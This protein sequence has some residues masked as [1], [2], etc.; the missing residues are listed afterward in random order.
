MSVPLPPVP[1]GP[2][3]PPRPLLLALFLGFLWIR[4]AAAEDEAPP[5]YQDLCRYKWEAVDLENRVRYSLRLCSSSPPAGCG[6]GAAACARG[7]DGGEE[8]SV[9]ELDLLTFS[10]S[11]LNFNST[12]KCSEGSN[13]VQT[14]ISFQCGKTLG[15]PELVAVSQCVHYFEWKSYTACRKDSFKPHTEVP[16][17]V[18][19]SDGKKHD[20]SPLIR[21]QDGYL[22]D[23][24]DDSVDFYINI[25]RSL[26]TPGTPCP[27]GSAACLVS[28]QGV[29]G[30]GSPKSPL[31]LLSGDSLR[32]QYEASPDAPRPE[33]C[34]DHQPAVSVTLLCPSSRSPGSAPK[35]TAES[36]CRFEVLWVTEFACHRDYLE[37]RTCRLSSAEHGTSIDLSP[38]VLSSSEPPYAAH[39]DGYVFYLNVCG[40]VPSSECGDDPYVSSC[41]VKKN[42]DLKKVAGRF[43]NQTLRFSD[44]DLTLIYPDGGRCS[45]GFHRMT[46][47]NF[48]CNKTAGNGGRGTPVF[49]GETDCSYLFS[50]ETAFSC[51]TEPE[52]L[53][54]RAGTGTRRYD[55]SP[56]TRFPG[57]DPAENWE[58][59]DS[60]RT[61]GS[62]FFLNV[63]HQVLLAGGA[64]G[65]PA[66]AA[67]CAL[68]EKNVSLSLGSFL[69][70]PQL[71]GT[72]TGT[73]LRL[74]YSEGSPCPDRKNRI[75]SII[76]LRCRPGDVDSAP[77]LRRVSSDGCLYE[78]DWF[79]SAACVLSR[80]Q[81]DNCRVEDAATGL[82]FDLSPLSRSPDRPYNVT[83]GQY[84]F[85]INVC[86]AVSSCPPGA[87]A[88]QVSSSD[89]WSLGEANSRLS[90]YDGLIQLSYANGS[91]YND[92]RHTLR[93]ALLA[94]LCDPEAGAGQPQFQEEDDYTYNFR[95]YTAYACPQ[96]PHECLVTDPKTRD[97][98]DLSSL[99]RPAS[100]RNWETVDL[101]DVSNLKKFY[102][103]V[104]RPLSP[105]PG[106]DATASA[107]Q[108]KYVTDQGAPREAVSIRNLGVS[109]RGPIIESRDRVLL[110]F[111]DGSECSA[112]GLTLAYRTHLH[113]V[114]S[115]GGQSS[116]PQFLMFQN[117]T[118]TFLWETQAA[119][120]ISTSKNSNCSVVD[121]NTGFQFHLDR[122]ASASGY[123]AS[124]NNKDFVV[125]ICADAAPCGTGAAGCELE[126]GVPS[127]PVGVERTLQYSTDGVLQLTYKGLL[128]NHTAT[129]DTFTVDFVC[130]PR[131][132]PGSLRL[133]RE[134]MSTLSTL[135]V[136]NVLFE[137]STALVC[138]PAPV[139][140]RI[141]DSQGNEYDLS[142]LTRSADD[143]PWIPLDP[144]ATAPR[145]FYINVCEP[146]PSLQDCP[147]G[148][149]GACRTQDGRGSNLGYVQS[150]PQV[151]EDGTV[152]IQYL[153][154]DACGT[155]SRFSTR[156]VFQCDDKPS[157]PMLD[158]QDGCEFVFVWRTPQACP[159]RKAQG[160]DCRVRDPRTGV[161]LD[162]SPLKGRDFSVSPP[163]L[164]YSYRL[165]VCGALRG[166]ACTHTHTDRVASCQLDGE[167]HRVAGL[168]SEVLDFV[169]DQII[170][171]YSGGETCHQVYQRTTQIHFQC[172]RDQ[173][174]GEPEFIRETADC[175]YLFTWRTALAC[176]PSRTSSCSYRD[177]QGRSYDL[178]SLALDSGNW[179]VEVPAQ[180]SA[181]RFFLNVC[182]NL[183]PQGGSWACPS[184]AASCMKDGEDYV[185]LGR[186]ETGPSW[187]RNV[188]KL[189][190]SGGQT[191]P[192]G[193]RN[194]TSIVRFKCDKDRVDSGPTLISAIE[195]CVFTFLWLT[196]AACPLNTTEQDDCQV[197]N[198]ATGR[199]F[200]LSPLFRDGGY[201]VLD[202]ALK[203]RFYLNVC[204]ETREGGCSSGTAVCIRDSSSSPPLS[205]GLVSRKLS[206]RDQVV[207][208]SYEGGSPCAASPAHKHRT[209][210]HFIC[211][212]P[213]MGSAPPQ[214]V[215]IHSNTETCTHF[216]SLHTAL[217][218]ER[219]V[220]C[221]VQN[222]S[223]TIDLTPLI[224]ING[225]YTA[226]DRSA[227]A[228]GSSPD[229]YI[230][231]CQPL[232][233]I[234]GVA[235]PPGAAVCMDPENGPPVD[236]GRPAA[237]PEVS[238]STVSLSYSSSTRCSTE[239]SQNVS[240]TIVFVCQ[241]GL[242]L[243]S[244]QLASGSGCSLLFRWATPLVCSDQTQTTGCRLNDSRLQFT[245]D[246]SG[247]GGQEQVQTGSGSYLLSV[248]G[249]VS[250][251]ACRGAAVCRLGGSGPGPGPGRSAAS[252]GVG[253]AM[254]M[255]FNHRGQAVLM[256]YGGGDPCPAATLQGEE[257]VFPFVF[258]KNSYSSCTTDG[259]HDN[260][261]WCS[262][263][264]NYDRD[265]RWG[266]CSPGSGQRRSSILF[267]C[268]E[269]AGRGSPVLLSET[270][271][272]SATFQWR[273]A[274]SCPPRTL[275]CQLVTRHL[276]F[277]LRPL[278]SLTEP[279]RFRHGGDTYYIN[280]CQAVH[281]GPSGC[282]DGA[283][284][285]RRT[286]AG[287]RTQTLGRVYTQNLSYTDG[288]VSV[289]YS[290]G[291]P[292]CGNEVEASA[293]IRL[294]CGRTVGRPAL[295]SLDPSSCR[296]LISWSTRVACSV[297]QQEVEMMNGTIRVPETGTVL[298]LGALFHSYHRASGDVRTNGDRYVYHVQ[299]SGLSH[300]PPGCEDAAVCQDKEDGPLRRPVGSAGRAQF[301]IRG[302]GLDAVIP[303]ASD[304]GRQENAT[305]STS[306]TFSC[307]PEAGAGIPEFLRET[308]DCRYMFQWYTAAVC[309]LRTVDTQSDGD[310][311]GGSASS[312]WGRGPGGAAVLLL[313]GVSLCLLGLLLYKRER[314]TLVL[315]K[316]S[317]CCRRG[318]RVSYKYSKVNV[319][320]DGGEEEME[321]LMEELEAPPTGADSAP[322]GSAPSRRGGGHH[323]NGHIR[324]KPVNTDGLRS[325]S[326][327]EQE[328][329]EDEVL[330]V[331]GVRVLR[332]T[333][334][335]TGTGTG[336]IFLQEESDEDLVGL[337]D[338]P[339][340]RK[341]RTVRPR[342]P[343]LTPPP[344]AGDQDDS[345][346]DLL[347]V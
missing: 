255:D 347:R 34:N 232:N 217:V 203:R 49:S 173:N 214:P 209:I 115:R 223:T 197:Q 199:V 314:R 253:S 178:S 12:T 91:R 131:S 52:N 2:R 225:F 279:W 21:L 222:G 119:C 169:G 33:R 60:S 251:P 321:W 277:D 270:A 88:C 141:S 84:V 322:S 151:A 236:V 303:S 313:V 261:S 331:P 319:D 206:F 221:S 241:R 133:V 83:S 318:T 8:R 125:N 164:K 14:S 73:D 106:C 198:P 204:G 107:C 82:S 298:S 156:I 95:W 104:C 194:R 105:V 305:V 100:S 25:C 116:G 69:S 19:D 58:V 4:A 157:S 211:R 286:A 324:T 246:L 43:Q 186:A 15:S 77:V 263:T 291:D 259:R 187:E 344:A 177:E 320:E 210:M 243:G 38:L 124:A 235:C 273:T 345:D 45:S 87:G 42:Q 271:G 191:C 212:P 343:G 309:P 127:K 111:S 5:W 128:D 64:A 207:E 304:C 205:A 260:R 109:R 51:V 326:L 179:E 121:P 272:C 234:P 200:D 159:V 196:A 289:V 229:F 153:N 155:S 29:F 302:A 93:S 281:G 171:K 183:V 142:S 166:P 146:L 252:F 276:T 295:V 224:N 192:D 24:G 22:V 327:D 242:E 50:W 288:N 301:F 283:A 72:G 315:Q 233:P 3:A 256:Q 136:H 17:A 264:E 138:T 340:S 293:E 317:S 311:D 66:G 213:S 144:E 308:G 103:N 76:T 307:S 323:S 168:S 239:P 337:L 215:F 18:F 92:R 180:S 287:G 265:Q 140:C 94:F 176:P 48:K 162:L 262:T 274:L 329:S 56:L 254:E 152:S 28:P 240:S 342:P 174:P 9:G 182:R 218:C 10:G 46:I 154:G 339:G 216:F 86:A 47:I 292:V 122:L 139:D 68:D 71:G 248:C 143:V 61:S 250:E 99:S 147:V 31:E 65:C 269:S 336:S 108:M 102:I 81:G 113:L 193:M 79:T 227:A 335:G 219:P 148:P 26:N 27:E 112:D 97:Q 132:H 325:F 297:K 13:T 202:E 228:A 118:A 36:N 296:F 201:S 278:S 7:L 59:V 70:P 341:T 96:R 90:Y 230:N 78:L 275:P 237:G 231:V 257:C 120:A 267:S 123:N 134:E 163:G 129:Q 117:C 334:T 294:S 247:L 41:Q 220:T 165:A 170:L 332:G 167:R 35:M 130:D 126:N 333:G 184:G 39:A 101:S 74:V 150:G 226:T 67:A 300:P 190:Y 280:L 316:V 11:V 185:G 266:F 6:T 20:L 195:D 268:D 299:L 208:L 172:H 75:S 98:Y 244:P 338:T 330:S 80:V 284:V 89:S 32:L 62:R 346:E 55:L 249:V 37:S 160:N 238:G 30:M 44:G 189:Q 181:R 1:P 306:I 145:T 285:C 57:S 328:D 282:P 310:D 245:F 135:V 312:S 110:E 188:L 149:L 16:C 258:L 53:P 54:C 40:R 114:C 23:D 290:A 137:F 63:C 158:R 85:F 161:L 175:S